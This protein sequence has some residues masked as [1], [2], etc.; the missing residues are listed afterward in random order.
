[1]REFIF[2]VMDDRPVLQLGLGP[3]GTGPLTGDEIQAVID[4]MDE[5]YERKSMTEEY[6]ER[7][8]QEAEK[9]ARHAGDAATLDP[10]RAEFLTAETWHALDASGKRIVL[11]QAILSKALSACIST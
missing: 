1:M 3:D 11:A 10:A 9:R 8:V 5:S 6:R 7:V 2:L 4:R